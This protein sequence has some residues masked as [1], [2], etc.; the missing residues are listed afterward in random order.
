MWHEIN[1][2]LIMSIVALVGGVMLYCALRWL[3]QQGVLGDATRVI[4]HLDGQR[5]FEKYDRAP[6]SLARNLRRLL[7]THHL[8]PRQMLW[9]V[10]MAVAAGALP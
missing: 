8:Q 3:R 1:T 7:S 9:L 10:L 2:P 5:I 4:V 6:G